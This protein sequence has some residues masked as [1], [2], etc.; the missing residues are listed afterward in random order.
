MSAVAFRASTGASKE[1]HAARWHGARLARGGRKEGQ[2][3]TELSL[4]RRSFLA[5]GAGAAAALAAAKWV[6]SALAGER[7]VPPG[8]L[9]IH[10]T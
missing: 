1:T 4:S 6:P 9:G 10:G 7:L 8:K 2:M 5:A 3:D